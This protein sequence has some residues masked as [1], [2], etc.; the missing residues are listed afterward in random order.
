MPL[1]ET[2][3]QNFNMVLGGKITHTIISFLTHEILQ[4]DGTQE[5][6]ERGREIFNRSKDKGSPGEQPHIILSVFIINLCN[7][8]SHSEIGAKVRGLEEEKR[9]P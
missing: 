9:A 7:S 8:E 4:R 2:S 3:L 1:I 5:A 6:E